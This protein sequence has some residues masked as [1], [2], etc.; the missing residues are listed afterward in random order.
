MNKTTDAPD[1]VSS[2][3][4]SKGIAT[5]RLNRPERL[6][7]LNLEVKR[8]IEK[9]I[10]GLEADEAVKVII[11]TGENGV[12]VAGTDIA[13][14]LEMSATEHSVEKTDQVFLRTAQLQ[15][16]VDCGGRKVCAWRRF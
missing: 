12:F 4:D 3:V 2:I 8:L 5:I 10:A 9:A 16:A 1:V 11:I 15:K 13:E 7:A 6:N 14:M